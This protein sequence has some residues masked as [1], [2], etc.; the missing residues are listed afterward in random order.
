MG[1]KVFENSYYSWYRSWVYPQRILSNRNAI[2]CDFVIGI[3]ELNGVGDI[4]H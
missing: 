2:K 3:C 1:M 4:E